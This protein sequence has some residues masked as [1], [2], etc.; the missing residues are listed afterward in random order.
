MRTS[1]KFALSAFFVT[2][3][4]SSNATA[5]GDFGVGFILGSPTALSAKVLL[6]DNKAV[7]FGLA[8][9]SS[10]Y[11]L[12]FGDYLV[13]FPEIIP[14]KNEFLR[15]LHPY[16]GIG[17]IFAF[18]TDDDHDKDK[19]FDDRDDRFAF[20]IRVPF[21]IE[22]LYSKFPIG[23]SLELAPGITVVPATHGLL[24]AGIAIRYY[25]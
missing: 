13:H 20:G 12:I 19:Y 11:F 25:F 24:N 6:A 7:D 2:L 21:G 23:V 18:A 8:F 4:L 16:I 3:A 9:S 1:F 5:K 17:P 22:W 10:E 15:D 14:P